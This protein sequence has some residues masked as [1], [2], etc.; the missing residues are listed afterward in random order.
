V[1]LVIVASALAQDV[2]DHLA[3]TL[4]EGTSIEALVSHETDEWFAWIEGGTG[5]ARILDGQTWQTTAIAVCGD[6]GG[7]PAG[8][9]FY[10]D[11]DS[12]EPALY[13]GCGDGTV[14]RI[15][16][17]DREPVLDASGELLVAGQPVLG[18]GADESGLVVA[19]EP[20]DGTGVDLY[21]L[22]PA[23]DSSTTSDTYEP[24]ATPT[25]DGFEAL[26]LTSNAVLVLH[27][28]QYA[29]E[30]SRSGGGAV[31]VDTV[32]VSRDWVDVTSDSNTEMYLADTD[33]VVGSFS[34]SRN[35]ITS[36]LGSA[37][38]LDNLSSVVLQPNGDDPYL[39]VAES[40]AGELVL[41]RFTGS[42]VS[43][44]VI[45]TLVGAEDVNR[46]AVVD[47]VL[48]VGTAN[49]L[50][51]LYT[52][53][54]WVEI[55][56]GTTNTLASGDTGTVVFE[57]DQAGDWRLLHGGT[58]GTE[59]DSGS[60]SAGDG[61]TATF[62]VGDDFSEGN[63]R[64]YVLVDDGHDS[65]DVWVDDPPGTVGL[66]EDDL[67]FG[68]Q[69]IALSFDALEDGDIASYDVYFSTSAFSAAQWDAGGPSYT[70]GDLSSPVTATDDDSG[71]VTVTLSP[72]TN[73]TTY[74]VAVRATDTAGQEGPMSTVYSA[75][76]EPIAGAAELSGESGGFF[77]CGTAGGAA[78]G[79]V[80]ALA[81]LVGLGRR[82]AIPLVLVGVMGL[83]GSTPAF[84][85]PPLL[86]MGVE[87]NS[88]KTQAVTLDIGPAWFDDSSLT[89]V[90]GDGVKS[91]SL[92]REWHWF[93][94]IGLDLGLG[95]MSEKGEQIGIY[96]GTPSGETAKFKIVPVRIGATLRLDLFDGQ[97]VVP[98]LTGGLD[99]LLWWETTSFD[100]VDPF[101]SE[102]FGG[103]KP[104]W[105]WG[106]GLDVLLDPFEPARAE[107][108]KARWGVYD[109]YITIRYEQLRLLPLLAINEQ[110]LDFG[111]S[112]VS[113]GLRL[114]R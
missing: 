108:V 46:M 105:D 101:S 59:L 89:D 74:Y 76:P 44:E 93:R 71:T 69:Y 109:T 110:G 104:A 42:T 7:A 1:I 84:A 40:K 53:D 66:S 16:L 113:V 103:G 85:L 83:M 91:L 14:E 47:D 70:E 34:T 96:T 26:G 41:F 6:H 88:R 2:P 106:I 43:T 11:S 80:L 102:R 62:V 92:A 95:L 94:I 87:D 12:D 4:D 31:T 24:F 39:A 90:Y 28:G 68:D 49:G 21:D 54:P 100:T 51:L 22:Q 30:V 5:Q 23:P 58:D 72:L 36:L 35:D 9:A 10:E 112:G 25:R 50:V 67:S 20:E 38:G 15:A 64:L 107:S 27:G 86:D 37:Q 48:A 18:L 32:G 97:P 114:D 79:L 57:S 77:A 45:E 81:G 8:L 61:A 63:N 55:T 75:S 78:G 52:D 3:V 13:V 29:T 56:S 111:Y 99:Y 17:D 19:V 98:V 65:F 82:R 60:I 73:Q 33:G